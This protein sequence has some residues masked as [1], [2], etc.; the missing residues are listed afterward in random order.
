M[1]DR[2]TI[3]I[4]GG[5]ADVRLTRADK[6]NALDGAM[7]NALVE[8]GDQLA[9]DESVR[10]VVLSGEGRAFCAGL[11]FAGFQAMAGA[12]DG[13]DTA[14]I[15]RV[16][17]GRITHHAQQACWTWR[18]LPMPV[19]AAVHGVAFGGGLQLALGA[20]IRIVAP[21]VRMSVLEIR[22]GLSPDMTATQVLPKL[23]GP[24]LAKE[25]TWTGREVNGEEA[26]RIGLATHVSDDPHTSAIELARQIAGNSPHAVRGAKHLIDL[27]T[28]ADWATGFA[29]ERRVIGSLIGRP[30]QVEAVTAYFEKRQAV[31]SDVDPS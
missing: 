24:D 7:F 9:A 14:A 28:H 22:W 13:S 27:S 1:S 17:E 18:E 23:V 11:D 31:Y 20:D 8:A 19:I 26:V 4:D 21:D 6:M 5:V 29:E 12:T 25:L 16:P 2:L 10:A 3:S 30:N 15:G